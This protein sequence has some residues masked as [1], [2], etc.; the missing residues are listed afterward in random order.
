MIKISHREEH[1]CRKNESY[2]ERNSWCKGEILFMKKKYWCRSKVSEEKKLQDHSL[3]GTY[4]AEGKGHSQCGTKMLKGHSKS[5]TDG[6]E[7]KC[8]S[9]SNRRHF[10][11]IHR[12]KHME[13]KERVTHRQEY[14]LF[15]NYS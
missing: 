6:T 9:K 5:G 11:V 15:K 14:K 1:W 13:Q 12:E 8:D 4:V 7:R 10:R 3:G 2:M